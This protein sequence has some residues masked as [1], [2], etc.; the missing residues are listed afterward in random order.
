MYSS[1]NRKGPMKNETANTEAA[2]QRIKQSARSM[3][4]VRVISGM[5]IGE[6][7]R[8]GDIYIERVAKIKG[9]GK[10]VKSRQL[11]PGT[12]K[13]S[14]H[15]VDESPGVTLWESKPTLGNKA[16]FQVGAAIEAKAGFSIT[17]PEHAWIKFVVGKGT[18]FF[19]VY[20][21]ADFARKERARD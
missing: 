1:T 10:S 19:Q 6:V 20:F 3:P 15:I 7:V 21:Q 2:I 11:A 5:K 18:K 9:K 12:S 13:G 17:H 8:Q 14:R 16:A 4:E